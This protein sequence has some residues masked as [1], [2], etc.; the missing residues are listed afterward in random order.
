[1]QRFLEL[2]I[3]GDGVDRGKCRVDGG[4]ADEVMR[5]ID[6]YV[7]DRPCS[8]GKVRKSTGK[9]RRKVPK[10]NIAEAEK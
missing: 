3:E 9:D 6:I 2:F 7:G 4:V 8:M 1:M 5:L 10:S